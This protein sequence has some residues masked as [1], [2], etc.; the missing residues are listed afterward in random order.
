MHTWENCSDSKKVKKVFECDSLFL[1]GCFFMTIATVAV[2]T[3]A[4]ISIKA[5]IPPIM[6]EKR[7]EK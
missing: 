2:I 7:V 1:M 3:I 5:T 4:M 6:A